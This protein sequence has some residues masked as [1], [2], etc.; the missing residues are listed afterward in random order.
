MSQFAVI[1]TGGKQYRV[2]PGLV[3][4]VELLQAEVGSTIELNDVRAISDGNGLKIGTP[5]V[6]GARVVAQVMEQVRGPKLIVFKYKAKTRYRRKTGH[7]QDYTRLQVRD[8][9]SDPV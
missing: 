4:D 5:Q 9:L 8:I 2:P 1:Q 3:V 7:R 6:N